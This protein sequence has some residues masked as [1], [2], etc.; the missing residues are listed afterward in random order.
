MVKIEITSQKNHYQKL[1]MSGHA[2]AG[3][4]NHDLVCAALTGIISGALNAFDQELK[5]DV[6]IIVEDNLIKMEVLKSTPKSKIMFEMLRVQ[7]ET[8]VRQY[9]KNT[10]LKE[11]D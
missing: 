4:Y 5:T 10:E 11:V 7:L 8:I 1:R 9:P 2:N 3:P 6:K